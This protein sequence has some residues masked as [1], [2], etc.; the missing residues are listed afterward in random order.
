MT[1]RIQPGGRWGRL[2]GLLTSLMALALA[3][4]IVLP[5][6]AAPAGALQP[7]VALAKGP[8]Q[9]RFGWSEL[10]P[11][12]FRERRDPERTGVGGMDAVV[13]RLVVERELGGR[14]EARPA[15][16]VLDAQIEALRQGRLDVIAGM[17]GR[18][19]HR[20][21]ARFSDPYRFDEMVVVVPEAKPGPWRNLRDPEALSRA[22]RAGHARVG[23]LRGWFYGTALQAL[24]DDPAQADRRIVFDSPAELLQA[25]TDGRVDLGLAERVTVANLIW[26]ARQITPLLVADQPFLVVP[27][28]FMFSARTVSADQVRRFNRALSAVKHSGEFHRIVRS[29]LLPLLLELTAEQWW[30]RKL[31]MLGVFAAALTG[32]VL[33]IRAGMSITGILILAMATGVGGGLLRDVVI[34][35]PVPTVVQNPVFLGLVYG[36]VLLALL[37]AQLRGSW[38]HSPRLE[39]WLD[40]VDALGIAAF[41]VTGVLIA[42]RM[43]VEPLL[44]WGPLLSVLT[45]GGGMLMREFIRGR[46]EGLLQRGVLYHEIT[47]GGSLL[48]SLF[49]VGYSEL[50]TYR[51]QDLE[52]AV[53]LT[54]A[55]VMLIR[56]TAIRC[57]WRSPGPQSRWLRR[58]PPIS[59]TEPPAD[60]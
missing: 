22:L 51:V 52:L 40:G 7:A 47:F 59:A 50:E 12:E 28:R 42:L 43:R 45:A 49:L 44:L 9:W 48:L 6:L 57:G 5:W 56:L 38:L 60:H 33:A 29:S 2:G 46:G 15:P 58:S 54:M 8:P 41:T 32:S 25:V 19:D 17:E 35:R 27:A 11:F 30:F 10:P 26:P 21:F 36:A 37:V 20:A 13:L 16:E 53:V 18:P 24:L 3:F 34:N 23:V 55:L 14:I 1:A 4:V 39:R 31:E